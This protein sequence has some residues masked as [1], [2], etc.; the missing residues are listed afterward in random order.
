M[1]GS[2]SFSFTTLSAGGG[3][4]E[5]SE[6]SGKSA[7]W[8]R[9]HRRSGRDQPDRRAGP[10]MAIAWETVRTRASDIAEMAWP[11]RTQGPRLA[12]II[13]EALKARQ[14][15]RVSAP[16]KEADALRFFSCLVNGSPSQAVHEARKR[17][18]RQ[19]VTAGQEIRSRQTVMRFCLCIGLT[20]FLKHKPCR[21]LG[22]LFDATGLTEL[23]SQTL[24]QRRRLAKGNGDSAPAGK[25]WRRFRRIAFVVS[26][27]RRRRLVLL[28]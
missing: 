15:G 22:Y 23:L 24:I 26:P 5:R 21:S 2:R 14:E 19:T 13:H 3:N 4:S 17:N 25:L 1:S 16:P 18:C 8:I 20:A 10:P 28:C 6:F 12:R 11:R 9:W 27:G 7:M